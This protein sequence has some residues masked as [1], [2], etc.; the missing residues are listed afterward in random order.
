VILLYPFY[1][2]NGI[3]GG[4]AAV[5]IL[6]W[7]VSTWKA[8]ALLD[9]PLRDYLRNLAGPVAATGIM[10]VA[11]SALPYLQPQLT[12]MARLLVEIAVGSGVYGLCLLV[13]S[14]HHMRH[15]LGAVQRRHDAPS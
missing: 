1:G 12:G 3:V 7:P 10:W 8:L 9:L 14:R 5:T 2:L 4:M 11:V 15:I 6:L 13:L